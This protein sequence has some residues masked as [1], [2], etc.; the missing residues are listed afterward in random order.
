[1][2]T[3]IER[4]AWSTSRYLVP[5]TCSY[6]R[7]FMKLSALAFVRVAN[8][9]HAGLNIVSF[10]KLSIIVARV[11]HASIGVMDQASGLR[12]AGLDRH[13]KGRNGKACLQV[14]LQRPADDTPAEGIEHD[15]KEREF[16]LQPDI[17]DV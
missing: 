9:A 5:S 15:G 2:N 6:L 3:P 17:R 10:Q 8:A 1:M 4:R 12:A 14:L 16:L 11:L 7:V 13:G